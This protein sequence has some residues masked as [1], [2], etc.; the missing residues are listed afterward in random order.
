MHEADI[1]L[2]FLNWF[3]LVFCFSIYCH[4]SNRI[5]RLF[6]LRRIY[7]LV[8]EILK[9]NISDENL[10]KNLIENLVPVYK[11]PRNV[12]IQLCAKLVT[13]I[14]I[15][16]LL[17][18]VLLYI[19]LLNLLFYALIL[20]THI[21]GFWIVLYIIDDTIFIYFVYTDTNLF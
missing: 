14:S 2:Y 20:L 19:V 6:F 21:C 5:S 16:C 18:S 17:F 4:F 13:L 12:S 10:S 11:L 7:P 15:F 3:L 1:K 9:K 8:L